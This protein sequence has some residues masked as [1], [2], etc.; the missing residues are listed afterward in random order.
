M[1]VTSSFPGRSGGAEEIRTPDPHNA[2]V[3]L[4]QLSYDPTGPKAARTLESP[5][6]LSKH[7]SKNFPI[8]FRNPPKTVCPPAQRDRPEARSGSDHPPSPRAQ[9]ENVPFPEL[10][11]GRRAGPAEPPK[12]AAERDRPKARSGSDHPHPLAHS[13]K[14]SP[15]PSFPAGAE[16][17]PRSP[18]KPQRSGIGPKPALEAIT[19]HPLAHSAKASPSPSFPAGAGLVPRSPTFQRDGAPLFV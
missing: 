2:I 15:S 7:F 19:L 13:A 11:C 5:T 10:P 8:H 16:L 3:V 4:Y 18:Q 1:A 14:A 6:G 9:R 17:V 12:P